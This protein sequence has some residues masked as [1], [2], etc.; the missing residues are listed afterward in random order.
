MDLPCVLQVLIAHALS[1]RAGL[2]F[3]QHSAQLDLRGDLQKLI[4]FVVHVFVTTS[5]TAR[6]VFLSEA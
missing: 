5:R 3:L 6:L 1:K 2:P 4:C